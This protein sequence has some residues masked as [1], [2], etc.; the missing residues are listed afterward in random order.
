MTTSPAREHPDDLISL[1]R[2][3]KIPELLFLF[4]CT[5]LEPTQL[6]PIAERLGVTVQAASHT[7]R[8]LRRK[9]MAE[10]RDG[11]YRPTVRG[12][13]WL[14]ESLNQLSEGVQS[15][16][17][18]LNIIRTCRAV[19]LTDFHAGDRASLELRNGLLSARYGGMGASHGRVVTG[20]KKGAL[21]ELSELEGIVPLSA[22]PITIRTISEADL[23]DSRLPDR[24][25]RAIPP[26]F[27]GVV[28]AHGLEAY[29]VLRS[30]V[31]SVITRFAV[32]AACREASQIGV[33]SIVL[34][35]EADLP[36]FLGEFSGPIP[37]PLTVLPLAHLRRRSEGRTGRR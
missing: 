6:R 34:V 2:A 17:D 15:R 12:V 18:R 14:H 22:A 27:T 36:R 33:P 1:R 35:L 21:V 25:R 8:L 7:Y 31:E 29:L 13:A 19:A 37:P 24:L 4:E 20:A 3:G 23:N 32:A 30:A 28:G 16:L 26:T 5:T 11:R 9:G 10:S